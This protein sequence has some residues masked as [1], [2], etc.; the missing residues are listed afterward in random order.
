MQQLEFDLTGPFIELHSLLKLTGVCDSGG[1]GNADRS[2]G[3]DLDQLLRCHQRDVAPRVGLEP[4]T[5]GLTVRC[6]TN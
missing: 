5:H 2:P 1:A 3:S 4:T 6:S